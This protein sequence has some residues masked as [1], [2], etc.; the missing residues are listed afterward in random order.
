MPS[1]ESVARWTCRNMFGDPDSDVAPVP[2]GLAKPLWQ[3]CVPG[4]A[5]L[6]WLNG[7]PPPSTLPDRV[8]E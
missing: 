7:L 1:I 5:F 3:H 4:A 6:F 8:V 2:A